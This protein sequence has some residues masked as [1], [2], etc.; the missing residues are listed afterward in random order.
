MREQTKTVSIVGA[1]VGIVCAV[2]AQYGCS[3][4]YGETT[5]PSVDAKAGAAYAPL[6]GGVYTCGS[7]RYQPYYEGPTVVYRPV[8]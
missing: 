4:A 8:Y 3:A 7:V 5:K 1:T 6:A 2:V